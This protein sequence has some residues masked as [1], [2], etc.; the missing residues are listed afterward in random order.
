MG[1]V[2]IPAIQAGRFLNQMTP[3]ER[4]IESLSDPNVSIA[5]ALRGLLVVS[6]RIGAEDLSVWIRGEL[7]GYTDGQDLPTYRVVQSLPIRVQF[8]GPFGSSASRTLAESDLPP[9]LAGSGAHKIAQP[10]AELA[11]LSGGTGDSD[12]HIPLPTWWLVKYRELAEQ[13]R[14]P[15]M[16]MMILNHAA[17][18]V[19]RT[20]LGG[21]L[22]RV[23][24]AA[25]DM[26]LGLEDV[27]LEAGS[28]GG[29]TV[30]TA[31][32]LGQAV[33]VHLNQIFA[34]N[35]AVV[36]GDNGTAVNLQVGD[37]TGLLEA[38]RSFLS[39]EGVKEL[40]GALDEDGGEPGET[41]RTFLD[42]VRA[43]AFVLTSGI[44][45]NAAYAGLVHLVTTVFP[46]FSL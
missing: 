41:T 15:S 3:L 13:R 27:S 24:S 21:I 28:A 1:H 30:E 39:D 33:T 9:E 29:P 20:F 4:A 10:V 43:G 6:R 34:T 2:V 16:E 37:V 45:T 26:A 38:A 35:S 42:R 14:A 44:A 36:V 19:P 12:P 32:E 18:V 5:D 25:L 31:P 23:K 7:D 22:D 11:A 8:D 17:I 46:G 40:A